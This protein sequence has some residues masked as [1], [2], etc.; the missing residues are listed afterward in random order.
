MTPPGIFVMCVNNQPK[1]RSTRRH[2]NPEKEQQTAQ[3][4]TLLS[5][6]DGGFKLAP[7]LATDWK[8]NDDQ[9][10][11][12]LT[13]RDGVKFHDGSTLTS[14]VAKFGLERAKKIGQGEAYLLDPIREHQRARTQ[15][16]WSSR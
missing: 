8:Y 7:S 5:Y 16:P 9:S 1:N 3:Y 13:L 4:D 12:T 6:E 14:E 11:L 10:E 15:R 2:S